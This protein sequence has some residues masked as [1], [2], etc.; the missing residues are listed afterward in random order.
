V[1]KLVGFERVS[2]APGASKKVTVRVDANGLSYWSVK[3]HGWTVAA[4]R[5]SFM[6]GASSRDIKLR[7]EATVLEVRP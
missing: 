7:T 3:D 6:V 2:L 1:K 5:R 4:G